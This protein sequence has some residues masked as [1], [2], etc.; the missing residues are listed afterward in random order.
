MEKSLNNSFIPKQG[1][2]RRSRAV[3][4]KPVYIFT[5]ISYI[6]VFS[7]LLSSG[8][9][10]MYSQYIHKQL[11]NQIE[12]LNSDINTFSV[13]DMERVYEFDLRL[14]QA[15]TRLDNNVSIVSVLN[16][17]ESSTV[18][19]V[20]IEKLEIERVGDTSLELLVTMNT[21]SFDSTI[22]Q[23]NVQEQK[24]SFESIVV[25]KLKTS[26]GATEEE[27]GERSIVN[28]E[29]SLITKV[30]FDAEIEIL[31]PSVPYDPSVQRYQPEV[32]NI[33]NI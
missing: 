7:A 15:F 10:Y 2:V 5:L 29:S 28:E 22:F 4:S 3:N 9:V 16:L 8:M 21:E 13:A 17:L 30:S 23:R 12:L 14:Q 26:T 25:K 20:E 33:D 31:L 27:D 18:G 6:L 11:A 24:Q 1:P 19:T 32:T